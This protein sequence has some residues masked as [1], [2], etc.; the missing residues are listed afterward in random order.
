MPGVAVAVYDNAGG[1]QLGGNAPWFRIEGQMIVCVYDEVMPHA[2]FEP[3]HI[4]APFMAEGVGWFQVG[5]LPACREGNLAICGH[6]STGRP[7]WRI[8][9]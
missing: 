6:P 3:L 9:G 4:P 1:M 8:E 5:G 7:W 2:P